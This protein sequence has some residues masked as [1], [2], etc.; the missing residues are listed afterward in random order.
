M[1]PYISLKELWTITM[2]R[3]SLITIPRLMDFFKFNNEIGPWE[4]WY[5]IVR[6]AVDRY[7]YHYPLY[8]VQ[9]TYLI[10][11]ETHRTAHL[12]DNFQDYLNDIITEDQ[13]FLYPASVVGL[14]MNAQL[15]SI[16]PLRD[17]KYESGEFTDLWY[18]TGQYWM[19]C[20]CHYP[21][22]E[23]FTEKGDP[24][25]HCNVYFIKKD[26]GARF[27]IFK[28][29]LYVELCRYIWNMR[30]NMQLQNLPIDVFQGLQDDSQRVQADLDKIYDSAVTSSPWI[31]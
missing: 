9:R 13:I 14:S 7:Q 11:D 3:S 12:E 1:I 8:R 21:M 22:P 15:S 30:Q 31:L 26:A 23:D 6:D 2:R 28:D 5:S 10:V 20:L 27:K 25:P 18:T 19:A 24:G 29:Q 17:Y 4:V 16:F